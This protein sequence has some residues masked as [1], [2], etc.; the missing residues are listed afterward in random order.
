MKKIICVFLAFVLVLGLTACGKDEEATAENPT[1][2][3][4]ESKTENTVKSAEP[5]MQEPEP[6]ETTPVEDSTSE[7]SDAESEEK[8]EEVPAISEQPEEVKPAENDSSSE[9]MIDGMRVSF[10][11]A[12]DSYEEFFDE[13]VAFM[14]KYQ[15]SDNATEMLSDYLKFMEQY[16]DMTKKMEKW[17]DG[18][19]ND[20]E[21]KY[22]LD[23]MNRVTQKLL[24]I[25]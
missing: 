12:M 11:E 21:L 17:N 18:T 2:G 20:A 7:H 22:Y 1:E 4:S 9:E 15:E 24:E 25:T 19:L 23:T 5:V 10:K 3:V 13:Y 8:I 16:S 6:V 14:K